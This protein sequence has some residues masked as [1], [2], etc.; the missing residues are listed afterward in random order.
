MTSIVYEPGEPRRSEDFMMRI[1]RRSID[2][3]REVIARHP[4]KPT[5]RIVV[6]RAIELMIEDLEEE[7]R[8]GI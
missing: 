6:Q 8:R 1:D 5:L 3:L 4:L 2:E 7:I